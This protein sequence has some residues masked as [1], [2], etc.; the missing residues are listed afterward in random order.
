[1]VGGGVKSN[2]Y[3]LQDKFSFEGDENVLKLIV[4]IAAQLYQC[5]KNHGIVHLK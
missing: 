2:S 1:M 4:V 3:W 5:T